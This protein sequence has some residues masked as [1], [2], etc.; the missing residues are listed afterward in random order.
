M[1][2]AKE[3]VEFIAKSLASKPEEVSVEMK[4]KDRVVIIELRV[5]PDDMGRI[6]GKA[7]RTARAIRTV[8]RSTTSHAKK[9]YSVEILD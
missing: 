5:S 3:L 9:K 4:E 2:R 6:I 7:G 1:Q 8:V